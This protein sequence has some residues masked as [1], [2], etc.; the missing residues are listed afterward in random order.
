[1]DEWSDVLYR[2]EQEYG[3]DIALQVSELI[4]GG[5][6]HALGNCCDRD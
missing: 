6:I 3:E 1:M 2:I 4:D 5:V